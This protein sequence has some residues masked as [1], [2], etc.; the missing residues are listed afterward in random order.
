M[1]ISTTNRLAT[2]IGAG[3]RTTAVPI[4]RQNLLCGGRLDSYNPTRLP[5]KSTAG[6]SVTAIAT[7]TSMPI[8]TGAPIVEKYGSRAK[9]RQ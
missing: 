4:R 1:P 8:A 5:R 2:K 9:L 3:Q 6:P 7:T